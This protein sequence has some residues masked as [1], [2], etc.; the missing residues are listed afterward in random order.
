MSIT[1]YS[2]WNIPK[3]L[4][5][6]TFTTLPD[7]SITII[8]LDASTKTPFFKATFKP[9]PYI[10]SIPV[11]TDIAKYIGLDLVLVQPP[12]PKGE[13]TQGELPGT[14]RW[15]QITPYESTRKAS[16][17]W[18][19]MRQTS[20]ETDPLLSGENSDA[21]NGTENEN[22]WPGSGRWRIGIVM[23]DANIDFP[24][25]KYWKGPNL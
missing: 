7:K 10:P 15:C 5:H 14:D 24:E 13:G 25:G 4:A 1:D 9:I 16:I 2:D 3:H 18:W 8:V 11:S 19:D 23:E 20:S 17:G 6:F 22:W 21:V 12:L